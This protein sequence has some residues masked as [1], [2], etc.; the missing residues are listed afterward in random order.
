M[1]ISHSKKE[2][3]V[4]YI[5]KKRNR[6]DRPTAPSYRRLDTSTARAPVGPVLCVVCV[7]FSVYV[8]TRYVCAFAVCLLAIPTYRYLLSSALSVCTAAVII[9]ARCTYSP[10]LTTGVG[11]CTSRSR[12]ERLYCSY[13]E[14][15]LARSIACACV[16][17]PV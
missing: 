13:D 16:C 2:E 1:C 11:V 15:S 17:V 12:K 9:A 7:P 8:C 10:V 14:F 5:V 6:R 4:R 3:A